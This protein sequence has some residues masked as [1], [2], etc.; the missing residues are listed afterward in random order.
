MI[1]TN[2][3]EFS[4]FQLEDPHSVKVGEKVMTVSK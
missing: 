4:S 1:V 3:E 2:K